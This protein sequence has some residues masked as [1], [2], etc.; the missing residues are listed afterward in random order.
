M[1]YA[2]CASTFSLT[3]PC[4]AIDL[5]NRNGKSSDREKVD[6]LSINKGGTYRQYEIDWY[7]Y[8]QFYKWVIFRFYPV[9]RTRKDW[10]SDFF[11]KYTRDQISLRDLLVWCFCSY[12]RVWY[13]WYNG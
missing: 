5:P 1:A 9:T 8:E 13:D 7:I 12:D 2:V 3:E 11:L 4:W 6:A 10:I